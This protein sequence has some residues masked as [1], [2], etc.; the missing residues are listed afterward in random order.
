MKKTL[1][2]CAVALVSVVA[3][4]AVVVLAGAWLQAPLVSANPGHAAARSSGPLALPPPAIPGVPRLPG[5]I[6]RPAQPSLNMGILKVKPDTGLAGTPMKITGSGL[7]KHAKVTLTWSTA[8]ST[9]DVDAN[10]GTVNYLGRQSTKF[11]V[12]IAKTTTNSKGS[13]AVRMRAPA[14]WGGLHDIYAV[15]NHVQ[16]AHGGFLTGRKFTISPHSGPIGTPI[17]ITYRGFAPTLYEG[18][19]A[20]LYDN[21]DVGE[22]MSNWTRGTGKAVIRAAGP[23][24]K[25]TLEIGDAVD[26]L[27]LN[28]QQAPDSWAVGGTATFTVT[29]DRGRPRPSIDWPVR[30]APTVSERTTLRKGGVVAGSHTH[31]K[32]ATSAGQV[33]SAVRLT[34][35]GLTPHAPVELEWSTVVGSRVNCTSTCWAFVSAPLGKAKPSGHSLRM[36][37][38]VPDG[39]GGWHV[40]QLLQGGKT[41]AQVPFYVRESVVGHGVSSLVLREGQHF[42]IHLKGVGWTQLDNTVGV[43]YDDSYIGYGCGFASNGDVVLNLHATGGPG[44]HIIDLY[45]MLYT[46]SPSFANTPYGLLPVLTY[47]RDYP[48]LALGYRLPAIRLAISIVR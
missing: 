19:A 45:P 36:K 43:D 14:D 34:A 48:G 17:T 1:S 41:L 2:S 3:L 5:K 4:S 42:T 13:F 47:G 8:N 9:W 18:G 35:T 11:A 16:V 32:L 23:V 40:V 26:F 24:G 25:H 28:L 38:R 6:A 39:L 27:Y 21:H 33:R 20:L 15:I 37:F 12:V 29:K 46:L 31:V 44:T 10:P 30:V 7:A 22:L